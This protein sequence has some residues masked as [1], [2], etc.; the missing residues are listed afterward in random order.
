MVCQAMACTCDPLV[1]GP[2]FAMERIPGPVCLC[3]IKRS[4]EILQNYGLT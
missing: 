3:Q 2:E 4:W 1:L